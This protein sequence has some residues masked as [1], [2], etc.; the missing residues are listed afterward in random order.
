MKKVAAKLKGLV[1]RP[2][3]L[4][5]RY[6]GEEFVADNCRRSIEELQIPHSFSKVADVVTISVGFCT[7]VPEKGTDPG[8]VIDAADHALYKAKEGGRNRVEQVVINS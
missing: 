1:N 8:L 2:G 5:A 3:D 4:V 6:G 7:V